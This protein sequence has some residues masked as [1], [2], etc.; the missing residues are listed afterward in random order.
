M[1]V[2]N[3][4]A[5]RDAQAPAPNSDPTPTMRLPFTEE[6]LKSLSDVKFEREESVNGR[7]DTC[8]FVQASDG[9]RKLPEETDDLGLE[10]FRPSGEVLCRVFG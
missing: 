9:C 4:F 7:A 8:V 10:E 1:S 2:A 5:K 6:G 3:A